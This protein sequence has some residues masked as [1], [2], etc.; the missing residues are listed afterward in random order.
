MQ[1][2]HLF[3]VEVLFHSTVIAKVV[4]YFRSPKFYRFYYVKSEHVYR[5]EADHH[6]PSAANTGEKDGLHWTK[7]RSEYFHVVLFF[8]RVNI[9]ALREL[10]VQ[11]AKKSPGNNGLENKMA[12][13]IGQSEFRRRRVKD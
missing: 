1:S 11:T 3:L 9:P 8:L 12:F 7:F 6:H 2:V 5:E 4:H 10:H 13:E